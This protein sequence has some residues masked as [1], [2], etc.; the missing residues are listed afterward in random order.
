[1]TMQKKQTGTTRDGFGKALLELG[2]QNAQVVTLCGDLKESMRV[3]WFANEFP[4]RFFEMGV[5]EEN[6]IGVAAGMSLEGKIPFACSYSVF[7]VNNTLGPIRASVCYTN[8]NVK[9]IGGHA[10]ITTGPDG[11]T[12]QALED[13]A[14][15][16]ALPNM[17]VVVPADEPEA[18]NATLALAQHTG[19]CYLRIGKYATEH[20]T[21]KDDTFKI[22]KAKKLHEGPDATV[23]V[24]GNLVSEALRAA[25]NLCQGKN[26]E[27]NI[28]VDV[29]NMHTIKPLDTQTLFTSLKKTRA[30]ITVEEHQ[31][32]G[33]LG[34]AVLEA[35]ATHDPTLLAVPARV[36]GMPDMFGESGE[37]QELLEKYQLDQASIETA[38]QKVVGLKYA[39]R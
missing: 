33:G 29:I 28:C 13:L 24:C 25:Q 39:R 3:E 32:H 1:M 27:P 10:G 16:R 18:Y 8:A 22:G 4:D 2:T 36:M 21:N 31:V 38:I 7:I 14:L 11:A 35:V 19:P 6:T 30:L 15:M 23:V 12:H 5:Q 37:G 9:V 17:T 34:S 26:G 20:V